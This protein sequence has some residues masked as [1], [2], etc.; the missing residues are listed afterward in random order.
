MGDVVW[1]CIF[2]INSSFASFELGDIFGIRVFK[3]CSWQRIQKNVLFLPFL[4]FF[5]SN[6][7][8]YDSE[9]L[10]LVELGD[11]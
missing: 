4:C 2:L 8:S 5:L 11:D 10:Q 1:F 3:V 7:E 9:P 6:T